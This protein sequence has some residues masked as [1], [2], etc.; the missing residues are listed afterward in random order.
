MSWLTEFVRP[1][2]QG[3]LKKEVPDNVWKNCDSCGQMLLIKDLEKNL[4]ICP[5]CNHHMRASVTQRFD[6]TFDPNSYTRLDLPKAPVDPLQFKD[7][8]KYADRLKENKTKSQLDES[9][10]VAHGTIEGQKAVVAVMAFEFM[11]GTMGAAFGEGFIAAARLA[12]AQQTPLIVYTASG[13]A[14][15]QEGMLSL[16][17]MPRT[18]IAVEMLKEAG[19][20]Y[21]VVFTDPTT[22][23]V[24]ASFAML[25]DIHIAEP[26]ALIG[27]AGPRV[28]ENTVHEK[29]PEGFQRSEYL[30]EHGMVDI[31]ASRKELRPTLA[32]ILRLLS[33]TAQP[34]E[35]VA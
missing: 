17:Q 23:G 5:H 32:K 7:K 24:T 16:M 26:N 2:I 29:L 21:I 30:L 14:R 28:I 1:K 20:P 4:N 13:G 35:K 27:F 33:N 8:K 22:G 3:F 34:S 31:V 9:I 6:W 10:V 18:V 11:A 25:G 12:L 15:M 19:I